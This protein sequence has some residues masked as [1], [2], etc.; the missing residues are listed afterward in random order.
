MSFSSKST[1]AHFNF[2]NLMDTNMDN[3]C[4]SAL[5]DKRIHNVNYVRQ[6]LRRFFGVSHKK[7][8]STTC[9]DD[10]SDE[11]SQSTNILKASPIVPVFIQPC[12]QYENHTKFSGELLLDWFLSHFEGR[13]ENLSSITQVILQCC[14]CLI[15]LGV[16]RT[17]NIQN[18]DLFQ[19]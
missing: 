10:I 14:T 5:N 9:F 1:T 11:Q 17:E 12:L 8:S 4:S 19:V 6:V 18:D 3:R 13:H 15:S 16:L 7:S 2:Q